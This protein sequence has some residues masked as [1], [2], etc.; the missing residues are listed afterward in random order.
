V[1]A[2]RSRGRAAARLVLAL[3]AVELAFVIAH[4]ALQAIT[5]ERPL[6][7]AMLAA[8]TS[9]DALLGVALVLSRI[10]ALALIP[11][12][13]ALV[14]VTWWVSTTIDAARERTSAAGSRIGGISRRGRSASARCAP[15]P[16]ASPPSSG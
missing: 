5:A 6:S 14:L 16:A 9:S 3:V 10:G 4:L 1:S 15:A 2:R 12:G 8:P 7:A 13:S 11:A